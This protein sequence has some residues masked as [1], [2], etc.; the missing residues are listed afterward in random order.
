MEK[1]LPRIGWEKFKCTE[2]GIL[3]DPANTDEMHRAFMFRWAFVIGWGH[4]VWWA[5]AQPSDQMQ[6]IE[7]NGK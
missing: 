2:T 3:I 5:L 6:R 1:F 4:L 7:Q